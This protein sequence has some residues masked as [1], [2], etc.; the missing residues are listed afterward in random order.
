MCN[1]F[2]KEQCQQEVVDYHI[3]CQVYRRTTDLTDTQVIERHI[4]PYHG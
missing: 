3:L 2:Q 4:V 1:V